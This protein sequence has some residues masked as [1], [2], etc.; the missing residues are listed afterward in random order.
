M[1]LEFRPKGQTMSN[2]PLIKNWA[3]LLAREAE[4]QINSSTSLV[5]RKRSETQSELL[6]HDI[7]AWRGVIDGTGAVSP[8]FAVLHHPVAWKGVIDDT[9]AAITR[10]LVWQNSVL[11]TLMDS[12]LNSVEIQDIRAAISTIKF[13][14]SL[15]FSQLADV[16]GVTRQAVY[17]WLDE[18]QD[19]Q[20]QEDNRRRIEQL[21]S[22]AKLWWSNA[23]RQ[24]PKELLNSSLGLLLLKLLKEEVPND[25]FIR[26]VFEKLCAELPPKR[27]F[28]SATGLEPIPEGEPLTMDEFMD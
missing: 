23:G 11:E 26:R 21:E 16:L 7:D 9:G 18:E 2:L 19:I 28:S 24:F 14:F 6:Q 17:A 8:Y 27:R 13:N 10:F 15:N 1:A 22:Y 5:K 3:E 4:D 12:A 20:I 25:G